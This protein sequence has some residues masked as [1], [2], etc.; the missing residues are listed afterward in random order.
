LIISFDDHELAALQSAA[1]P[2]SPEQRDQFLRTVARALGC[3]PVVQPDTVA[4]IGMVVALAMQ[5]RLLPNG[6]QWRLLP[7][8][9]RTPVPATASSEMTSSGPSPKS[10]PRERWD[11]REPRPSGRARRAETAAAAR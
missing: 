9:R 5:Q 11:Q 7:S 6:G 8:T 3:C 1:T 2:L 10:G 4:Q